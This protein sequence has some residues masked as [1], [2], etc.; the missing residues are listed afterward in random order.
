MTRSARNGFF[1]GAALPRL[2]NRENNFAILSLRCYGEMFLFPEAAAPESEP[3]LD[4][5]PLAATATFFCEV[6][7]YGEDFL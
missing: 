5:V 1:V 6:N 4:S 7:D 3:A 2:L